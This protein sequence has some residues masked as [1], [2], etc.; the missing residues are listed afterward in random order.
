[1]G[2][3]EGERPTRPCRWCDAPVVQPSSRW[4]RRNYCGKSHRRRF[5]ILR[6]VLEFLDW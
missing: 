5:R 4:R 6:A 1:M 2:G 3:D